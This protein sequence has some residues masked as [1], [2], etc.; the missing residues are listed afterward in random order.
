M[1]SFYLPRGL[2]KAKSKGTTP[3]WFN[4][5]C[6]SVPLGLRG[7]PVQVKIGQ[8]GEYRRM[9]SHNQLERSWS[10]KKWDESLPIQEI[11]LVPLFCY[12]EEKIEHRNIRREE[13]GKKCGGGATGKQSRGTKSTVTCQGVINFQSV[14]TSVL[15]VKFFVLIV[16]SFVFKNHKHVSSTTCSV[17]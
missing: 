2:V 7:V 15:S 9:V 12:Q 11:S 5:H 13:G 14:F 16:C 3:Y 10:K 4:G 17:S 6:A 1:K 8:R